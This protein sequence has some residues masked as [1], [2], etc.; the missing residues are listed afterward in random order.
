MKNDENKKN[1]KLCREV[2]KNRNTRCYVLSS[3]KIYK[4]GTQTSSESALIAWA[5]KSTDEVESGLQ[6][7]LSTYY[8]KKNLVLW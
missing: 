3:Q 7:G 2:L 4:T 6:P 5:P 1:L 8:K